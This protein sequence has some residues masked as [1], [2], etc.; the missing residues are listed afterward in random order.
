MSKL[1]AILGSTPRAGH[2]ECFIWQR[3][4]DAKIVAVDAGGAASVGKHAGEQTPEILILSHD[5]SDHIQGAVELI[6]TAGS[7]FKELWVPAEW[8]I[9]IKQIA[10]TTSNNLLTSQTVSLHEL[11]S[12]ITAE[13]TVNS[14]IGSDELSN[15]EGYLAQAEENLDAWD[16]ASFEPNDGFTFHV[17]TPGTRGHWYGAS[18][19]DEILNRVKKRAKALI[20]IFD[21]AILMKQKVKIRFFSVDVALSRKTKEWERSGLPGTVTLAN[22]SETSHALAVNVP[23]GLPYA[24]ALTRLTVQNR[25]ALC[26]LLWTDS[27][28]TNEGVLIWSDTDGTWLDH[29]SPLGFSKVVRTAKA[30][31]APHHASANTAHDRVW[32][33]LLKAP[34][35][36]LMISAGGQKNQSYRQEYLDLKN[37]RCCTKCRPTAT[38][39]QEVNISFNGTSPSLQEKCLITH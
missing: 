15:L 21:T 33:E 16:T 19:L 23:A 5:D 17:K 30:S 37:R 20:R 3:D 2:G 39:Y 12:L 35:S 29:S 6:Q 27:K 9:L 36:L 13:L 32:Q 11:E 8:G 7:A 38:I 10:N 22:A 31:S 28:K 24:Y 14:D 34:K 4:P 26:T 25:R 18:G 1:T